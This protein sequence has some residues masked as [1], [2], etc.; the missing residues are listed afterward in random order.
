MSTAGA[1]QHPHRNAL[2]SALTGEPIPQ[3]DLPDQANEIDPEDWIIMGSDGLLTLT[4]SQIVETVDRCSNMG[5][6]AVA[7]ALIAAIEAERRPNQDNATVIVVHADSSLAPTEKIVSA[8]EAEPARPLLRYMMGN[9]AVVA[10]ILRQRPWLPYTL[11]IGAILAAVLLY[12]LM[13]EEGT[14]SNYNYPVKQDAAGQNYDDPKPLDWT[15]SIDGPSKQDA[16]G[17]LPKESK[18][19]GRRTGA[20]PAHPRAIFPFGFQL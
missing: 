15:P 11:G 14:T 2:R 5:P 20:N 16:A 8:E 10:A 9:A 18:R 4:E 13:A 3:V 12:A 7:E 6:S 17:Q 19:R 1:E